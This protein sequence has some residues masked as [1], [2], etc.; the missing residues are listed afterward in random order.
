MSLEDLVIAKLMASRKSDWAGLNDLCKSSNLDWSRLEA[1]VSDPLEV[2]IN[3]SK[4]QW[5]SF[6]EEYE[7]FL[8]LKN[9]R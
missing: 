9:E 2:Q 7:R 6:L 3:M 4:E 1:I 5:E 8:A